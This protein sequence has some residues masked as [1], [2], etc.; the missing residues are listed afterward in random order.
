MGLT[1]RLAGGAQAKDVILELL[2]RLRADG[3]NYLALE[4]SGSGI[5]ALSVEDRIVIANMA[6]E[7]GAKAAFPVDAATLE[8]LRGVGII[9]RAPVEAD[10]GA[11]YL[12]RFTL[13]LGAITP[14]V[15]LPHH[16]DAV[17]PIEQAV[18]RAVD[19]VFIGTC[20]GGRACDVRAALAIIRA[21][22]GIAPGVELVITPA[23]R[24]DSTSAFATARSPSSWPSEPC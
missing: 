16:V 17:V 12:D 23:S 13:D 11:R 5:A 10:A 19:M 14:Q 8:F 9:D 22:G 20:T 24:A 18:G 3:A 2:N 7:A 6:T 15:A 21:A 4:F 1:G